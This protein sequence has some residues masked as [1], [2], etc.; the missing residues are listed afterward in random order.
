MNR[1]VLVPTA[2]VAHLGPAAATVALGALPAVVTVARGGTDLRAAAVLL[3]LAAGAS[4]GWAAEDRAKDVLA[5]T[6]IGSSTR[7]LVR[8]A[9]VA[10]AAVA[11]VAAALVVV[12]SGPGL[13]AGLADRVPELAAA[14]GA[15]LAAGFIAQR[16]GERAAGA[17]AVLA[18]LLVPGAV[19]ATAVRW[20]D[21]F[22]T[23]ESGGVHER[24][25][26]LAAAGV[27]VAARYGRD[28]A[29]R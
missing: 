10:L 3:A 13:P 28:P 11:V 15:G 27:V 24:W 21:R 19:A 20:P 16:R 1:A 9:A 17:G 5:A 7:A 26:L 23:F 29:G 8:V 25:W 14:A 18:G 2:R 12:A 6:P 4:L 22:P